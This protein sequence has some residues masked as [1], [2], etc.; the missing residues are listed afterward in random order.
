MYAEEP[1]DD[2]ECTLYPL[3]EDGLLDG[4]KP[5]VSDDF[6]HFWLKAYCTYNCESDYESDLYRKGVLYDCFVWLVD[7]FGK[8]IEYELAHFHAHDRE[9]ALRLLIA[10]AEALDF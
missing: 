3:D 4:W 10:A 6:S 7:D 2:F 9:E 1:Y 5:L 8:A